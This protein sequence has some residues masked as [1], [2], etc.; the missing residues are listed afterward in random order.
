MAIREAHQRVWRAH[1]TAYVLGLALAVRLVWLGISHLGVSRQF[2]LERFNHVTPEGVGYDHTANQW[3]DVWTRWDGKFYLAIAREG[4]NDA[5]PEHLRAAFFPLYP[6][7]IAGLSRLSG[8]WDVACGL[9]LNNL[10]DVLGWLLL[11]RLAQRR[12]GPRAALAVVWAF[13]WF[14]TRNFGFSLY[15]EGLFLLLSVG[16]F[17]AYETRRWGAMAVAC[18]AVSAVRPQGI[19]V[20]LALMCDAAWGRF[21]RRFDAPP[22]AGVAALLLAPTG[23]LA[24]MA[25]L[26]QTFADPLYFLHIQRV[27]RREL[28]APWRA[29]LAHGEPHE[30]LVAVVALA[31]LV[32][33]VRRRQPVRDW[34]YTGASLLV[35]L[36][37]GVLTSVTRFVGVLFPLFV[38]GVMATPPRS[39]RAR[40]F[41]GFVAL[42][43]GILAFKVGQG[44]KV[45]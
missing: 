37:T 26:W 7:L 44:G 45:I 6:L 25:F 29:L 5:A 38:F 28:A 18:A 2:P 33:M 15:T 35:P 39:W 21:A 42:Y 43:L 3:L 13:A 41:C 10:F 22:R 8:V 9:L 4:Y 40:L 14:P 34:V 17:Y 16:A 30:H 1:P 20:G 36:S 11:A 31:M 32:T 19:L 12:L 27:W 23:L 24:Y